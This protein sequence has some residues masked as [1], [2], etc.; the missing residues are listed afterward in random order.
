MPFAEGRGGLLL[1]VL[2]ALVVVAAIAALAW[3]LFLPI[4]ITDALHERTQF[5]VA[6]DSLSADPFTAQMHARGIAIRNPGGF[7]LSDF[8]QV[9]ELSVDAD[10]ASIFGKKIVINELVIDIAQLTLVKN[11]DGKSNAELFQERL[12]GSLPPARRSQEYLIR[13]LMLR[14]DK[15]R[16]LDSSVTPCRVQ[17]YDLHIAQAFENVTN[18]SQVVLPVLGQ[19][20]ALGNVGGFAGQ[21]GADAREA[22]RRANEALRD[23][24]KKA[25]VAIDELIRSFEQLSKK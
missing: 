7:S 16:F 15:L 21:L 1:K 3:M 13:R 25:G 2:A 9:R 5:G 4:L 20:T 22:V 18:P 8:A 14:F 17:E 11:K 12:W 6:V 23:A 24:G 10:M 19:A